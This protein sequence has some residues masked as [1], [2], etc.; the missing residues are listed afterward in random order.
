MSLHNSVVGLFSKSFSIKYPVIDIQLFMISNKFV[1]TY[2]SYYF[3]L[4][5]GRVSLGLGSTEFTNLIG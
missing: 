2:K 1:E 5:Y 4:L 3:A